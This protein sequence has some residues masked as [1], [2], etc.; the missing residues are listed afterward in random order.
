[1]QDEILPPAETKV[2]GTIVI[3]DDIKSSQLMENIKDTIIQDAIIRK[4]E[5]F[6]NGL[7]GKFKALQIKHR[8]KTIYSLT[9][10]DYRVLVAK[11][12]SANG[13]NRG[14]ESNGKIRLFEI[15][16]IEDRKEI[17]KKKHMRNY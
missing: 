12:N 9:A 14:N 11:V 10:G 8:G 7:T 15:I 16:Q 5:E 1:L 4:I 6:N 13:N 3:P 17:W 2:K